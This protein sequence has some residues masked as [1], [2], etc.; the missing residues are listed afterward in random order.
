MG[1]HTEAKKGKQQV[2]SDAVEWIAPSISSSR[3]SRIKSQPE[4]R[5]SLLF[6]FVIFMSPSSHIPG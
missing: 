6:L 5:L 4:D 3:G 2:S 1:K